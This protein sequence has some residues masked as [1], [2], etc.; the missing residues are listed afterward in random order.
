MRGGLGAPDLFQ[1]S[2][3]VGAVIDEGVEIV[4]L[5]GLRPLLGSRVIRLGMLAVIGVERI[6]GGGVSSIGTSASAAT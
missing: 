3:V 1:I 2:L 5:E 4:G 6:A